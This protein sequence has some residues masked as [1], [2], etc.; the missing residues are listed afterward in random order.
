MIQ[1]LKEEKEFLQSEL[2][3]ALGQLGTVPNF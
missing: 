1:Q 2:A 3:A